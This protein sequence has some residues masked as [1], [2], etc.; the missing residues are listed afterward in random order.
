MDNQTSKQADINLPEEEDKKSG[1]GIWII[2]VLLLLGTNGF[3][4][5]L[6]Y[7]EVERKNVVIKEK[8]TVFVERDNVKENLLQLQKEFSELQTTDSRVQGELNEK[9]AQIAELIEQAEKHKGDAYIIAKLKKEANTL[10]SIMHHY[11]VEIDSLGKLNQTLSAEK[12]KISE[13]LSAEQ[14]K[15]AQLSKE[16]D[17]LKNIVNIGSILKASNVKAVGVRFKSGGAKE[18]ETEKAKRT[19]KIKVSFTLAENVIAKAGNHDIYL[20]VLTPDGKELTKAQDADHMFAF[21]SS[22]GFFAAKK[23]VSY[24][25]EETNVTIYTETKPPFIPGKY[26]IEVGADKAI[27]GQTTLTLD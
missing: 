17:D 12:Q 21:G 23:G 8:E 2:L 22:K 27:I 6:Y 18:S 14:G 1:K 13:D 4:G 9:R 16:K 15:T 7:R 26:I 20:R 24:S 19:E 25:N 11:V 10:R 5:W 3:T